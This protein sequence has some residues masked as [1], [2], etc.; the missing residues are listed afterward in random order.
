MLS[1]I[2]LD[3]KVMFQQ[4]QEEHDEEVG[5]PCPAADE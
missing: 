3:V 1:K 4:G 2:R 5:Y